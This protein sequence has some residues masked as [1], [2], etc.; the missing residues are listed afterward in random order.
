MQNHFKYGLDPPVQTF[1]KGTITAQNMISAKYGSMTKA[2]RFQK[3]MEARQRET[4]T[5]VKIE[6]S[7]MCK[8]NLELKQEVADADSIIEALEVKVAFFKDLDIDSVRKAQIDYD[9]LKYESAELTRNYKNLSEVKSK[10][11]TQ[12]KGLLANE[13]LYQIEVKAVMKHNNEL[14]EQLRALRQ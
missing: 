9:T 7:L 1:D 10:I 3:E 8:Q 5:Q 6:N 13:E 4:L 11:Q 12:V 14:L 2:E